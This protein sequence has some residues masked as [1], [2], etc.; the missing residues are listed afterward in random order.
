[1]FFSCFIRYSTSPDSHE[2]EIAGSV[3]KSYRRFENLDSS[4]IFSRTRGKEKKMSFRDD[5]FNFLTS[6]ILKE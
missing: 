1:M 2:S 4:Q 3:S 5:H 6:R